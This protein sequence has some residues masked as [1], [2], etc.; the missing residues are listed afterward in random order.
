MMSVGKKLRDD[1]GDSPTLPEDMHRLLDKLNEKE[2][3]SRSRGKR[4]RPPEES[5]ANSARS[6]PSVRENGKLAIT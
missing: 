4:G 1:L 6:K 3:L 2:D 5:E